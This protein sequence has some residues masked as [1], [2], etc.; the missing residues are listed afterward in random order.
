[1]LSRSLVNAWVGPRFDASV[2]IIYILS[3]V[4]AIRVGSSTSTTLLKGAGRH[5]LLAAANVTAA[6]ANLGLSIAFINPL[7]LA[8]VAFGTLIPLGAVSVLLVVPTACR[9]V[10]LSLRRMISMAV[11]PALWPAV[12]M[13]LFLAVTGRVGHA[14]L[15]SVAIQSIAGGCVYAFV[16]VRLA[17]GREERK[18]YQTRFRQVLKSWRPAEA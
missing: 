10:G 14:S 9:H 4:V 2:Q 8:G 3:L 6:I 18:W 13:V 11:W 15:P 12:P 17:I 1:M 16:F 5:K 7:G